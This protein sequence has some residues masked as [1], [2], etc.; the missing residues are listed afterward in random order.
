MTTRRSAECPTMKPALMTRRPPR[1]SK[2]SAVD[3]QFHGTPV[4]SDWSGTPSTLASIGIRYWPASGVRGAIV[5]P[6]F[7]AMTV[8]TLWSGDGLRSGSQNA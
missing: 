2:Y 6:Q 5:K 8:V 1:A 7:P 4:R 3:R